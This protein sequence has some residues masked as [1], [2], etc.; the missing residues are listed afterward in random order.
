MTMVIWWFDESYNN[1]KYFKGNTGSMMYLGKGVV[2][3]SSIKKLNLRILTQS[4]LVG[5]GDYVP[6]LTRS[7][8]FI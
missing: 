5:A 3:S 2:A 8:Y 4:G 1:N 7:K 6:I